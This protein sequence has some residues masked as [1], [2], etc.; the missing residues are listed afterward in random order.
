L[1]VVGATILCA[2]PIAFALPGLQAILLIPIA[3]GV[4]LLR[5]RTVADAERLVLR[6]TFSREVLPW[7]EVASLRLRQRSWVRA[8]RTDG[9]EVTLPAVRL[10]HLPM[11]AKVSGGRIADPSAKPEEERAPSAEQAPPANTSED[12][13]T[14]AE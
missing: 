7:S 11:L 8:V 2:I 6:R 5:N 4:W 3:G 10:R 14:R 9:G 1:L 12:S 13:G